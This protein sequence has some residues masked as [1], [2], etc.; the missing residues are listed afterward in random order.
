MASLAFASKL[1]RKG[2]VMQVKAI[3][4]RRNC[5]AALFA[6]CVL[7][8]IWFAIKLM[9]VKTFIFIS[10]SLALLMLLI[11]QNRL[12][13]DASLIWENRILEVP[14][15][16]LYLPSGKGRK[17]AEETIVST[18]GIL[19]GSKIY[20]WGSEGV[21]GVRL[22]AIAIDRARIHLTFGDRAKTMQV[23]LL[24]GLVDEQA[25][26]AVKQRLWRETGV[27]ATII[28]W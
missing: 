26:L 19:I 16:V 17:D 27:I 12:L 15:A 21:H 8:I 25:V 3:Q 10:L 2:G 20:K 23:E 18:F 6:V 9:A 1:P 5:Y 11:R 28:G 13:S 24:H 14:S 7:L 22:S 4:K